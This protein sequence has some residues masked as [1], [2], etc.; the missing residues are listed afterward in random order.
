M[1]ENSDIG[2]GGSFIAGLP[3]E[4]KDSLKSMCDWLEDPDCPLHQ[5]QLIVL[6]I[7]RVEGRENKSKLMI[8]PDKHGYTDLNPD[9]KNSIEWHNGHF[10]IYYAKEVYNN[11]W[12]ILKKQSTYISHDAYRLHNIGFDFEQVH[13]AAM[14]DVI[15]S[16]IDKLFNPFKDKFVDRIL[17]INTDTSRLEPA[18]P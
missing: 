6:S 5:K 2:L 15:Y 7:P 3:H 17:S 8:D 13:K 18:C 10:D 4:T 12:P 1:R 14:G 9:N 16:N 11:I